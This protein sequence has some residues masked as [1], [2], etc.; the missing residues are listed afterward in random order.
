MTFQ[1]FWELY[2]KRVGKLAAARE[3]ARLKPSA[4]ICRQIAATLGWQVP[5][6][7]KEQPRFTPNPATWL[8]Q[9]RWMD[10]PPVPIG[11]TQGVWVCLHV[12]HCQHQAM[13]QVKLAQPAKYPL[14]TD[15]V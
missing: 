6:W 10:E 11:P 8:H 2:P 13:C 7:S 14:R 3:W 9:G 15:L 12:E 1:D 5:R 4:E